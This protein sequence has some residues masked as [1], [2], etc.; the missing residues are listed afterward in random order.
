VTP[1]ERHGR[2]KERC[3]LKDLAGRSISGGGLSIHLTS[4]FARWVGT[5]VWKKKKKKQK[6]LGRGASNR[7]ALRPGVRGEETSSTLPTTGGKC[8]AWG[9][10]GCRT[11]SVRIEV[12]HD[13][14]GVRSRF[15]AGA[16]P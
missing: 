1:G 6:E 3:Q 9:E 11:C 7:R 5:C 14:V 2:N 16:S 8:Q 12:L 10:I 4:F 15:V 13:V